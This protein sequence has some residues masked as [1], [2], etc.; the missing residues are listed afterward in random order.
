MEEAGIP[1]QQDFISGSLLGRQYAPV[2]I[3]YPDEERSTSQAYLDH[4]LRSGRENLKTYPRTL[5]RRVLF[6][7]N[8]T[9]TVVE[10]ETSLY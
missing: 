3:S 6:N 1:F 10:L 4:A 5:A 2:T 8:M 9:A 7:D